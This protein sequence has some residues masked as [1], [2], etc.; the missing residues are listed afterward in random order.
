M[1][2]FGHRD[3]HWLWSEGGCGCLPVIC[4]TPCL[5]CEYYKPNTAA[6]F[7]G[8]CLN[9]NGP[10]GKVLAKDFGSGAYAKG[11]PKDPNPPS[12]PRKRPGMNKKRFGRTPRALADEW[13]NG[14]AK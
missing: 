4:E 10:T 14:P 11:C 1:D 13:K 5:K 7:F 9:A 2:P 8:V 3:D 12:A 6:P